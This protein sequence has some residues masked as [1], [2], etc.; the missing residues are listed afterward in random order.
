MRLGFCRDQMCAAVGNSKEFVR[1]D[2][3]NKKT[4]YYDFCLKPLKL[5]VEYN[6]IYFHPRD[7]DEWRRKDISFEDALHKDTQKLDF[8]RALGYDVI[9]VWEDD[10]VECKIKEIVD[11]AKAKMVK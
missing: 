2:I 6:G 9:V 4:Y 1:T 8:I 11:Y 10:D 5:I 7:I 3:E